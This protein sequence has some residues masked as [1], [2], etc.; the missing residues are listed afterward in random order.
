MVMIVVILRRLNPNQML[1]MVQW[2]W[3]QRERAISL[4]DL[5]ESHSIFGVET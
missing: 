3:R 2:H 4:R 1:P 5:R